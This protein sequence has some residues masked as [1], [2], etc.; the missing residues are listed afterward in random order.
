MEERKRFAEVK[1]EYLIDTTFYTGTIFK[2]ARD[3]VNNTSTQKVS[4]HNMCKQLIWVVKF[5]D[6]DI[7]NYTDTRQNSCIN[8]YDLC[9]DCDNYYVSTNINTT[10]I[11]KQQ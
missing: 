7:D 5:Y 10:N 6:T 8:N 3:I 2:S 1:H 4:F 11:R 9:H